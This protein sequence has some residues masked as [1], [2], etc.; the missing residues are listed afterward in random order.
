MLLKG[1][2]ANDLFWN[3]NGYFALLYFPIITQL[4]IRN[5][6][7]TQIRDDNAD[8]WVFHSSPNN[9]PMLLVEY[10]HGHLLS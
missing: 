10:N 8:K 7:S 1:N 9:S 2:L 5:H 6:N 4:H 3:G